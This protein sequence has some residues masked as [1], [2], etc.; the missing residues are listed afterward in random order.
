MNSVIGFDIVI[1]DKDKKGG[2][3]TWVTWK[4][5]TGKSR[6]SILLGNLILADQST[7]TGQIKGKVS[8]QDTLIKHI[9]E[10]KIV[11]T[12]NPSLWVSATVDSLKN[13]EI[14]LPVGEYEVKPSLAITSAAFRAL[15]ASRKSLKH[16]KK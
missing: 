9:A 12:T 14:Q 10:V 13:H 3:D 15:S 6:P 1:S 7:K 5:G 4:K 16:I 11:S 8:I 2:E